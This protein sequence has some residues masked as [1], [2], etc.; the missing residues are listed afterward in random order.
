MSSDQETLKQWKKEIEEAD[1]KLELTEEDATEIME[2]LHKKFPF[3]KET[4]VA[5]STARCCSRLHE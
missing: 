2:A 4:S 1:K 5:V 3:L